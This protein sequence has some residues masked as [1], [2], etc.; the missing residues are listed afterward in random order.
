MPGA[1][2]FPI[3]DPAKL[4]D[5]SPSGAA[6]SE[7]AV[8]KNGELYIEQEAGQFLRAGSEVGWDIHLSANGEETPV[9]VE[10]AFW[11]YPKGTLPKYRAM[12]NTFGYAQSH[13]IET[14]LLQ[15]TNVMLE[16]GVVHLG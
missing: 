7:W 15:V 6:F 9:E 1:K 2:D 8:G 3:E 10:T 5:P 11:F 16:L 13:D 12:M 14:A 4:L